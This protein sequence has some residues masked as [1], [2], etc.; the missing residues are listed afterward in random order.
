[1]AALVLMSYGSGTCTK[2]EQ[3]GWTPE[4]TPGPLASRAQPALA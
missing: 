2:E 4:A 3:N 1:M